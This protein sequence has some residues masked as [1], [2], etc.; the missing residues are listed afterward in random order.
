MPATIELK[1]RP[2]GDVRAVVEKLSGTSGTLLEQVDV[3]FQVREGRLKLRREAGRAELIAYRRPDRAA[4]KTSEYSIA[5]VADPEALHAVL[6]SALGVRSTVRKQRWL[7]RIGQTRVHLD[8]VEG[9]GSFLELEYVLGRDEPAEHGVQEIARLRGALDIRD[10]DLLDTAYADLVVAG[11]QRYRGS[12]HCGAVRFELDSEPITTGVRCNCSI[13][14][15][16]GAV[17]SPRY[18]ERV[19]VHGKD[20]L[21]NYLWGDRMVNH[22][23]CPTCGI[24]PFSEVIEKPETYRF[25]L[26]CLDDFD[27]SSVTVHMIDGASY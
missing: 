4:V 22:F 15:R 16:R 21:A 10:E 27:T 17:M 14:R 20:T 3:F 6:A 12:C 7:Y 9:L 1:A 26:G 18:Y 24:H 5:P 2:R 13:C 25:N 19:E 23:F 11:T 8:E